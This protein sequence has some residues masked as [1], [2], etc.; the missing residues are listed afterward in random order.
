MYSRVFCLG[1]KRSVL[2]IENSGEDLK[3]ESSEWF[4]I[5]IIM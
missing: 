2:E 5:T 4:G 3:G 1:K